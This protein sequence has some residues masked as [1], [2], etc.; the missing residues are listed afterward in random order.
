V[1]VPR[2]F[3]RRCPDATFHLDTEPQWLNPSFSGGSKIF[4][5]RLFR[6]ATLFAKGILIKGCRTA[7]RKIVARN[8]QTCRSL[9]HGDF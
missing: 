6:R 7:V 3:S 4:I 9:R 1:C 5:L 8:W 2:P